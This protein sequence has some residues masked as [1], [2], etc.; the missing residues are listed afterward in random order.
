MPLRPVVYAHRGA[1][2]RAKENTINSFKLAAEIGADGVELDVWKSLD[3]EL[4]VHHDPVVK[5][6]LI[7]RARA[8]DLPNYVPTL[9]EALDAC[10]GLKVNIEIKAAPGGLQGALE[11]A[12]GLIDLLRARP[13]PASQW[14]ISSFEHEALDRIQK[15]TSEFFTGLLFWNESWE[16]LLRHALENGHGAL[17]PHEALVDGEMRAAT[18]LEGIHL[19]TWTVNDQLRVSELIE[20]GIDGLITDVPDEALRTFELMN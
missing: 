17:H 12:D 4:M 11:I 20:L 3:G 1:S 14:V 2:Q 13:E 6:L 15:K 18:Q 8:K 5:G 9:S 7:E 19:N 10:L 16:I